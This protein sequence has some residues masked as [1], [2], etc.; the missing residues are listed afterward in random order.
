MPQQLPGQPSAQHSQPQ[1]P[2]MGT[3]L[4]DSY[5]SQQSQWGAGTGYSSQA[6]NSAAPLPQQQ[7]TYTPAMQM[8]PLVQ[9]IRQPQ[10]TGQATGQTAAASVPPQMQPSASAES[11]S[12]SA[13]SASADGPGGAA[14]GRRRGRGPM[15]PVDPLVQPR[16]CLGVGWGR[17][18][19]RCGRHRLPGCTSAECGHTNDVECSNDIV[20]DT[21][22]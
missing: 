14:G 6:A 1:Q 12:S 19:H 22:N 13:S 7:P 15:V 20:A 4:P 2:I 8:Q 16:G 17:G 9:P 18:R 21:A 10:P 3:A 11:S 5:F